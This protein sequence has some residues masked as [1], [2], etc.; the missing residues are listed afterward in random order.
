MTINTSVEKENKLG[1]TL[2]ETGLSFTL[3]LG[4][5]D[6]KIS[7]KDQAVLR[8]LAARV[9]ELAARPSEKE[10]RELW[11]RHNALERTR[12]VIFCDPENGWFEI[13]TSD[14]IRCEGALARR[15]E[16]LL[17]RE[18]FWGTEMQ[19]DRVIQPYFDVR[20]VFTESGWGMQET[21][22][23][24]HNGGAYTWDPPLKNYNDLQKL[25]LP[26]I[27]VDYR[28]TERILDIAS[29]T[30]EGILHVRLKTAWWWSLGMTEALV[31]LRGL[32]QVMY[33]MI[34]HPDELH[35]LMAFLRDGHLAKLDF[36]EQN[37]LLSL[38]ND[39]TYVGSGGFGWTYELPQSDFDGKVRAFDMWGF[40]ESQETVG[41]SPKMFAEFV[42]PYQLPILQRFGLNCYGCCEPLDKRWHIIQQIPR[43]RRVSVSPW[44]DVVQMAEYL[45]DQY[46]FSLKPSPTDLAMH[47]FDEE[48]IRTGLR[49]SLKA[50]KNCH[51]EIIMKDNHTIGNDPHR[52]IRW[53]QIAREESEAL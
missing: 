21:T 18:I 44:A 5:E 1:L 43:L 50:T 26:Q 4:P 53:V 2:D 10:K 29:G 46:I 51:V 45:G 31:K 19:D 14:Q 42:F 40:S 49:N 3:T 52:V 27:T 33:D 30:F 13:V 28:E 23:G 20:H 48:R 38:N 12:P 17:R 9:A 37:G 24:G 22:I 7:F 15:W 6:R 11:Y 16:F 8:Q 36:L 25:Q 32:T 47:S 35:R 39:G 34:D 41:I